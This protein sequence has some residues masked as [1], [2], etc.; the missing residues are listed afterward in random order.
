MKIEMKIGNKPN[1]PGFYLFKNPGEPADSMPR[2][3][4]IK[5]SDGGLVVVHPYGFYPLDMCG[6]DVLWSDKIEI[7]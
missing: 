4:D 6:D 5:V 1:E 7:V 2:V 3:A